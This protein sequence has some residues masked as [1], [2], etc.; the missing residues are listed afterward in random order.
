MWLLIFAA[1]YF[2]FWIHS[3]RSGI[4]KLKTAFEMN[5]RWYCV[6]LCRRSVYDVV[7]SLC[8]IIWVITCFTV[9]KPLRS[10]VSSRSPAVQV[11]CAMAVGHWT[12]AMYEEY[13]M[14]AAW[15]T[16]MPGALAECIEMLLHHVIAVTAYLIIIFSRSLGGVGMQG[17]FFEVPIILL[18]IR[19]WAQF[20]ESPWYYTRRG[21]NLLWAGVWILYPF[22]RGFGPALWIASLPDGAVKTAV[23]DTVHG[24]SRVIWHIGG[25][26]FTVLN[27]IVCLH[28]YP[29]HMGDLA[30]VRAKNKVV[31]VTAPAE[32]KVVPVTKPTETKVVPVTTPAE[33]KVTPVTKLT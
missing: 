16:K 24:G 15:K 18:A 25:V 17:L 2:I 32:T 23:H 22:A 20:L 5:Q 8:G 9:E 13:Y 31:P 21:V 27:L 29:L 1:C 33:E 30:E 10:F 26:V 4:A 11:M 19:D 12:T 28:Y 3:R 14:Y 6:Y 7:A